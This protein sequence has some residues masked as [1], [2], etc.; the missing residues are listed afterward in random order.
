MKN[1]NTILGI[2]LLVLILLIALP[3]IMPEDKGYPDYLAAIDTSNVS[4]IEILKANE[5]VILEKSNDQWKL[6]EP[7]S[8][9]ADMNSVNRL[10]GL[11]PELKVASL[12]SE[13]EEYSADERFELN[14][15]KAT[16]VKILEGGRLVMD[17]RFGK[18]TKDF[19]NGFARYTDKE[20]IYRMTQNYSS[21]FNTRQA[22]WINKEVYKF[23]QAELNSIRLEFDSAVLEFTS[24]DSLWTAN[25]SA[26]KSKDSWNSS[27]LNESNLNSLKSAV[28]SLRISDLASAETI[29]LLTAKE[30]AL[31]LSIQTGGSVPTIIEYFMI[32]EEDS[33]IYCR[34]NGG[35]P[36]Y[37]LFK[38]AYD[39][40]VKP[41]QDYRN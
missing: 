24:G 7:V 5:S 16:Q 29:E 19:S 12:A 33:K 28:S 38:S 10:L 15:E 36:W 21:R 26:A 8:Y 3:K 37:E 30:A 35:S 18:A 6:I 13:N 25:Y 9:A 20:T 39:R 27:D 23:D 22:G 14:D 11:L 1:K 2:L 31:K 34:V 4:R 32:N 40:L 17:A 41:A